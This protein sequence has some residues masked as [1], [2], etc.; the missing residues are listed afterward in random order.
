MSAPGGRDRSA[1]AIIR[2][3]LMAG[4]LIFGA[5]AW[6]VH[7]QPDWTPPDVG[8]LR[9][10]RRFVL[11]SWI[12]VSVLL[13]FFRLRLERAR[14]EQQRRTTLIVAWAVAEGAAM[15]GALDFFLS[16]D[17]TMF[18][19]GVFVMAAALILFPVREAR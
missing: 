2:I 1:L 8:S 6:F 17:V 14:N 19:G 4:V 13:I 10:V 3:A 11:S 15:G 7:R 9:A 5:V 16:R 18:A 12:A